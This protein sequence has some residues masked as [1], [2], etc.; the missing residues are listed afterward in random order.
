[1]ILKVYHACYEV[2]KHEYGVGPFNSQ[3][4]GNNM[5][6]F[7]IIKNEELIFK[8]KP[9]KYEKGEGFREDG[10]S[11]GLIKNAGEKFL[12]TFQNFNKSLG[13]QEKLTP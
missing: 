1:M 11:V 12:K 4:F 5:I 9:E 10:I 6:G 8:K 3:Y 2:T 7:L 13:T